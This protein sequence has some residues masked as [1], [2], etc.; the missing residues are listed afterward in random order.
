MTYLM[1]LAVDALQVARRQEDRSRT[2]GAG[3]GRLLAIM[4]KGPA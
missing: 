1:V 2:F 4:G 3:D